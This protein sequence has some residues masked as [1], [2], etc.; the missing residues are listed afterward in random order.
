MNQGQTTPRALILKLD[1]S[2]RRLDRVHDAL[3]AAGFQ[4]VRV[5]APAEAIRVAR[6]CRPN[7]FLVNDHPAAGVDAERWIE[8]QHSDPV[9]QF[10]ITPLVI[11]A[12][13]R[14]AKRLTLQAIPD[15]VIVIPRPPAPQHLVTTVQRL[16]D[17]W[18]GE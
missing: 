2:P 14:R 3:V 16:V 13:P 4:V 18:A 8:R 9:A 15:R 5:C 12:G 11:L 6:R 1:N 17:V 7:V 10:A